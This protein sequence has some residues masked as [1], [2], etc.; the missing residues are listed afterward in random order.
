MIQLSFEETRVIGALIEKEKTTP[1]QYPLSLNAL[2]NACNQKSNREPVVT[3]EE[4]QV[5][6]TLDSLR[7]KRLVMEESGYGSRVPKFKHRFANTEFGELQFTEQEL[8]V[9]TVMFLRGPQTPGE[10]RSRTNRLCSF[11][12]VHEVEKVLDQLA[13]RDDGP[14]VL[15]LPREPGKRE[16]RYAHLFSGEV[17][18][19]QIPAP[20]ESVSGSSSTGSG[21]L[22]EL[23]QRVAQLERRLTELESRL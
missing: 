4:S 19:A 12:D 14:F 9:I 5:Q 2:T 21:R 7:S 18:L 3:F 15:K 17:D 6:S 22:D 13:I 16:S 10:L 20:T 1:E 11:Q 23:E 8:A